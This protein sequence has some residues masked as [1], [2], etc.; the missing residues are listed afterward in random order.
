[1]KLFNC[2]DQSCLIIGYLSL[3][4]IGASAGASYRAPWFE[5]ASRGGPAGGVLPGR[6][7]WRQGHA[8][9]AERPVD[10]RQGRVTAATH[11]EG[12][13]WRR[14]RGGELRDGGEE[15]GDRLK[16]SAP[17]EV[18]SFTPITPP[19][20]WDSS[21]RHDISKL[22]VSSYVTSLVLCIGQ[23]SNGLHFWP[24]DYI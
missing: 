21:L 18:L 4:A 24:H 20:T 17:G 3:Q 9:V 10:R 6:F 5:E 8:G 14:E 13:I 11:V 15:V 16:R 2:R 22:F 7:L 23:Y 1:M 19:N 12:H